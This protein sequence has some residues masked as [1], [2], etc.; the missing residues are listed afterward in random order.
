MVLCALQDTEKHVAPSAT[1]TRRLF[2]E[3]REEAGKKFN[4]QRNP[5]ASPEPSSIWLL[6]HGPPLF[7]SIFMAF[8]PFIL[9]SFYQTRRRKKCAALLWCLVPISFPFFF[10]LHPRVPR[11]EKDNALH[12]NQQSQSY[13]YILSFRSFFTVYNTHCLFFCYFAVHPTDPDSP[14]AFSF[15]YTY[16]QT[17]SSHTNMYNSH[18]V[19]FI[20]LVIIP[21]SFLLLHSHHHHHHVSLQT[22]P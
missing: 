13:A 16:T 8:T 4:L 17:H 2:L 9:S 3:L 22:V 21:S 20:N 19:K 7:V 15:P 5:W 6:P 14:L 10:L 12:P 18:N 11:R 1:H